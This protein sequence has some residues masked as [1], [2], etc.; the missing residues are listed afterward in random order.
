V[1]EFS[2]LRPSLTELYRHVVTA[3]VAATDRETVSA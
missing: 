1:H 2:L 3:D